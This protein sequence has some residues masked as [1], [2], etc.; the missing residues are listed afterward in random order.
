LDVTTAAEA[1]TV[2]PAEVLRVVVTRLEDLAEFTAARAAAGADH[3]LSHVA[4]YDRDTDW[5]AAHAHRLDW[6]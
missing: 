5:V 1:L 6:A 2:P 4:V 3:V